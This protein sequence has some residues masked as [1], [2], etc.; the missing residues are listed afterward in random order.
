MFTLDIIDA[1][2]QAIEAVLDDTLFYIVLNWNESNHN[3]EMSIRN[4]A[5]STI[6][7]GISLVPNYPLTYQF[8]YT[9]MPPGELMV[10]SAKYRNGPIPRNGFEQDYELVY[11]T[12]GELIEWGFIDRMGMLGNAF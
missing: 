11:I 1:N 7:A 2:S 10:I 4:S 6:L 9:E 3:W 12:Q 8:R 5:Y